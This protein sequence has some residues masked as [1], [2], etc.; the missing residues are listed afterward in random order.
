[1]GKVRV[2]LTVFFEEPFW[3]GVFERIEDGKLS[4]AKVT[5]GAE[6][7]DYEVQDFELSCYD[8]MIADEFFKQIQQETDK[9]LQVMIDSSD[10]DKSEF[11]LDGGF[12]KMRRCFEVEV[13]KNELL[14]P[15]QPKMDLKTITDV[16][17]E[18]T[19]CC[20]LLYEYYKSTHEAI[21]P[22]TF[23]MSL[24]LNEDIP[25]TVI[26]AKEDY[27]IRNFA[28]VE[29]NEIAYVGSTDITSFH[30]FAESLLVSQFCQYDEIF[31][32]CDD[33]DAAAM[34]LKGFF[35]YGD[36]DSFDTYVKIIK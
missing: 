17:P 9:P 4:V 34:I 27:D 16:D 19:M 6:P 14:E 11:V 30:D 18:Y 23:E 8:P 15:I 7:K 21:N 33:V 10:I 13:T 3:V 2:K 25:R 32:E 29:D 31:F 5:F 20:K 35:I 22:V 24:F 26:V 28:F 1:M 12:V 36:K